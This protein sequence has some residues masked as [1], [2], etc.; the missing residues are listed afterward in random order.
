MSPPTNPRAIHHQPP[1][2]L[3]MEDDLTT[4]LTLTPPTRAPG[5]GHQGSPTPATAT[6]P[7]PS[8]LTGLTRT[9]Y[10]PSPTISKT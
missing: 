9:M 4:P 3:L 2:A 7:H 8:T 10:H 5:Q 6:T 1:K